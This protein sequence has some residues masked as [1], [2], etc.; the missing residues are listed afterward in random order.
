MSRLAAIKP[1]DFVNG[2][3]KRL[4][5]ATQN[6]KA[7]GGLMKAVYELKESIISNLSLSGDFFCYPRKAINDLESLLDG[8]DL[9]EISDLIADFYERTEIEIPGITP[10]DWVKVING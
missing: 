7:P 3:I 10:A 9:S 1:H 4:Q 8:A 5:M 6:H 2:I